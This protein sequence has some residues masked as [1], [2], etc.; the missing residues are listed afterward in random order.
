M[1]V[2]EA[3]GLA[4]VP[5]TTSVLTV[6]RDGSVCRV[7]LRDGAVSTLFAAPLVIP[8]DLA[9]SP[10]GKRVYISDQG[11]GEQVVKVFSFPNGKPLG[12][13][14]KPG[15]RPAIGKYDPN[16]L[17]MP[18]GLAFDSRGRLWVTEMDAT[19]KRISVWETTGPRGKLAAEYFGASAYATCCSAD[20]EQP[21]HVFV[22]NTRWIVDYDKRTVR[23]DATVCRPGY[24]GPQPGFGDTGR[25]IEVRHAQGHEFLFQSDSVWEWKGDHAVPICQFGANSIWYDIN[26]DGFIQAEE[27]VKDTGPFHNF[28]WGTQ[29]SPDMTIEEFDGRNIYLRPVTGWVDGL[30]RWA[31]GKE[32]K[33]VFQTQENI[34]CAA[35]N[36]TR[37]RCY[38][39]ETNDGY[40]YNDM[41]RNGIACYTPDG[42]RLWRYTAGIGMDVG[43]TPLTKP[44]EIRGAQKFLGFIDSGAARAGELVAVNGYYGNFNMLCRRVLPRQPPRA[45]AGQHRRAARRL[46]RLSR[47]APEDEK[48]LPD[49]RRLRR[50]HLGDHR[51]RLAAAPAGRIDDQ[52]AGAGRRGQGAGR[53]PGRR[54]RDH[55]N[56]D[57]AHR[58]HPG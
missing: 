34:W 8:F 54:R 36:S 11:R 14:G 50:A 22:H 12:T 28:Y 10:D 47:P 7:D 53:L 46:Q 24:F 9:L 55:H 25:N 39:L 5:G 20:P 52:P 30:P 1:T 43:D 37:T 4:A 48:G 42:K 33:P 57:P 51:A 3:K 58:A 49:G 13:I 31:T 29:V 6:R 2:G 44:G 17:F 35:W 19:P 21:E 45:S 40:Y 38:V 15:G 41:R 16:G 56:G 32:L 26:G 23:P 27:S 18:G